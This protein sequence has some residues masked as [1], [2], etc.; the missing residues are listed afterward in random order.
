MVNL[1]REPPVLIGFPQR[2]TFS[3][4]LFLNYINDLPNEMKSNVKLFADDTSFLLLLKM[5]TKVLM[6]STMMLMKLKIVLS[7]NIVKISL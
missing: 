5:N 4:H 1:Y 7:E 3:P 2:S 6:F